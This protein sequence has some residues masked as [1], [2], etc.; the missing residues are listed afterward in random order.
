M[1]LTEIIEQL[2]LCEYECEGGPLRLNVAFIE[3]KKMALTVDLKQSIIDGV[4]TTKSI[5]NELSKREGVK[6]ITVE[7]HTKFYVNVGPTCML[8]KTG[9]ARILVVID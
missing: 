5:V 6:E 7:P 2:E 1:N 3:L 4:I 9:P 8:D